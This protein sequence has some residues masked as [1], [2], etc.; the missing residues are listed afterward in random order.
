VFKKKKTLKTATD[1]D[2]A[3]AKKVVDSVFYPVI[4]KQIDLINKT[5]EKRN[6]RAGIEIK[7][8]F[9]RFEGEQ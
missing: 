1:D 5:L 2:I 8:F 9:D 6:I 7:W 4:K 3:Y